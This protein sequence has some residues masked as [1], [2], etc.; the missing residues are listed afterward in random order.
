MT[1]RV[2]TDADF[3]GEDGMVRVWNPGP[4]VAQVTDEGHLLDE[5]KAAWVDDNDSVRRAVELGQLVL[6]DGSPVKSS[7]KNSK[8]KKE[9]FEQTEQSEETSPMFEETSDH[10]LAAPTEGGTEGEEFI[11]DKSTMI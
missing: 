8:P 7:K 11:I 4:S 6:M 2:V 3:A 9:S 1:T 5:G 10:L